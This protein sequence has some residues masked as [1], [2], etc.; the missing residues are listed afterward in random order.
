MSFAVIGAGIVGLSTA[1]ELQ[2]QYPNCRISIF[3]EKFGHDT[4]SDVAA[5]IFRPG[6]SFSGPDEMITRF[7]KFIDFNFIT[8]GF[9]LMSAIFEHKRECGGVGYIKLL[10][11]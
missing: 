7:C 1:L 6:P 9:P 4:T 2:N 10:H 11:T 3:A 5:G 8:V